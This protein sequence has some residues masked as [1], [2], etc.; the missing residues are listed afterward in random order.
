VSETFVSFGLLAGAPALVTDVKDNRSIILSHCREI[1]LLTGDSMLCYPNLNGFGKKTCL[2]NV[3]STGARI[4]SAP[5]TKVRHL[6][7]AKRGPNG[8]LKPMSSWR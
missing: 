6:D 8:E 3:N 1:L 5:E 4:R 2:N 7:R